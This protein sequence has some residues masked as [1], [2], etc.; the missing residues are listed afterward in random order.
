VKKILIVEDEPEMMKWL[1]ETLKREGYEIISAEDGMIGVEKAK[2]DPPD[3][4]ISDI[5]M[6]NMNGFMMRELL[7]EDPQTEGTP[8]IMI[9]GAA[10]SVGAWRS[11]TDVEYLLKPFT[12]AQLVSAVK[13]KI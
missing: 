3:L 6:D 4:I 10:D 13:K 12:V 2:K 9:T 11:E 5:F 7:Q 1:S 8:Y